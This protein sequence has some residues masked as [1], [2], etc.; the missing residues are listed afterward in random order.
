LSIFVIINEFCNKKKVCSSKQSIYRAIS[1]F[2]S[3][4]SL[5]ETRARYALHILAD[6]QLDSATVP[7][8]S[9]PRIQ[10]PLDTQERTTLI[11]RG[12]WLPINFHVIYIISRIEIY[13]KPCACSQALSRNKITLRFLWIIFACF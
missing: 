10:I 8:T 6:F 3:F 11:E 13:W 5:Y 1:C 7:F 9:S 4:I 2:I 12:T